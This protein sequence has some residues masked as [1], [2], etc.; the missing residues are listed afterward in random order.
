MALFLSQAKGEH[1]RLAQEELCPSIIILTL[2]YSLDILNICFILFKYTTLL[3]STR[4]DLFP[5]FLKI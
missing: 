1:G 2:F 3:T 4:G 5:H